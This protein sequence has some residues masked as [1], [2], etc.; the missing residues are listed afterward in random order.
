MD[1]FDGIVEYIR[2]APENNDGFTVNLIGD[3]TLYV[4]YIISEERD[5]NDINVDI[6]KER[7]EEIV[8]KAEALG[9]DVSDYKIKVLYYYNGG[10]AGL[11]E[12]E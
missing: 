2:Y 12:V 10:C 5:C 3:S 7:L 11:G 1:E 4:D 9:L 8:Q 6:N